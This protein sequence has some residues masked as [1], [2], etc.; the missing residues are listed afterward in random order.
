MLAGTPSQDAGRMTV[1]HLYIVENPNLDLN[2]YLPRASILGWVDPKNDASCFI[3]GVLILHD[4]EIMFR[5]FSTKPDIKSS[6][7]L[8]F[9]TRQFHSKSPNLM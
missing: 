3:I 5:F 2:L 8:H 4:M 7:A 6:N 9:Q 1:L